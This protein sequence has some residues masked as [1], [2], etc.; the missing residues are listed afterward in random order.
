MSDY[1]YIDPHD[2]H[3]RIYFNDEEYV[4]VLVQ[5]F[6]YYDYQNGFATK[7]LY[8]YTDEGEKAA[9]K[10]AKKLNK[11]LCKCACYCARR[12]NG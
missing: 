12:R 2:C 8:P 9:K 1:G 6:D 5:D 3:Y 11:A 10:K 7:K 4:H